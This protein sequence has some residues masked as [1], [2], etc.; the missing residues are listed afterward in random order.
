V[1]C[2]GD[3]R[4]LLSLQGPGF[5][6]AAELLLVSSPFRLIFSLCKIILT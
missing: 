6:L 2:C 1:L 4:E 5:K 3:G